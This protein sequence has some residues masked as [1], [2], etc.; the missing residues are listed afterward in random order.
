[1][2]SSK[3]PNS[4]KK[5]V[6]R[7]ERRQAW[8]AFNEA[9]AEHEQIARISLCETIWTGPGALE[10]SSCMG[11]IDGLVST[12]LVQEC[13]HYGCACAFVFVLVLCGWWL[14]VFG[15]V[16]VLVLLL[17]SWGTSSS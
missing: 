13:Y 15:F 16:S 3:P 14:V 8:T 5:Q 4:W 9:L 11:P 7:K 12:N 6:A 17:V 1:M 2:Q 10:Y